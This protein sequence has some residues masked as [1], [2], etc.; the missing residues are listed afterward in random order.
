MINFYIIILIVI[1]TGYLYALLPAL[2]GLLIYPD[3][4]EHIIKTLYR[5]TFLIIVSL[6]LSFFN[7][8]KKDYI[9]FQFISVVFLIVIDQLFKHKIM[10]FIK[11]LK[12]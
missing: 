6:V 11:G 8:L 9:F 1:L 12:K 5:T 4:S 3:Y 2:I 10:T 7:L